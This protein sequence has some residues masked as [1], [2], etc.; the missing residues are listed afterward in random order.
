[1]GPLT[2]PISL[3]FPEARVDQIHDMLPFPL[4][5]LG[6]FLLTLFLKSILPLPFTGCEEN[7]G[8]DLHHVRI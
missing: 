6:E 1:M 7:L 5:S 2:Q 3:A 8:F 4:G